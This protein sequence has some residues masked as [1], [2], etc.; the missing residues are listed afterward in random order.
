M[1]TY[2]EHISERL[3]SLLEKNH[4]AEKGFGKASKKA[5]SKSLMEWFNERALDRHR[6]AMELKETIA[7][8][9]QPVTTNGSIKGAVHRTWMD[10]KTFLAADT[11][12]ALIEEAIRGEKAALDEYREVLAEPVLPPTLRALLESHKQR[13][14]Q[15]LAVI[16]K[17]EN[18]EFERE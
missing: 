2:T 18:I 10:L 4:D 8:V 5:I 16:E 12:G 7:S 1:A 13:M 14:E 9:G 11:D 6:F 17:L 15:G 3:N